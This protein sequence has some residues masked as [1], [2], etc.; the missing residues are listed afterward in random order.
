[1]CIFSGSVEEVKNTKILV[2]KVYPS[3]LVNRLG[4]DGHHHK[5]KIPIASA[6]LQLVIYSNEVAIGE[7]YAAMVLPFP[8]RKGDNRIK[9]L[10][11]SGYVNIFDDLDSIFP[12]AA[13]ISQ[14]LR[15]ADYNSSD[16]LPVVQV[17]SYRATLVPNWRSFDKVQHDKF[18]LHPNTRD[19]LGKHYRNNYGFIVCQLNS[20][21]QEYHP[22]A[23]CHE[24]RH[25]GKLFIPTRHYHPHSEGMEQKYAQ[26]NSEDPE[27]RWLRHNARRSSRDVTVDW[28]HDIY[29]INNPTLQRNPLFVRKH[30]INVQLVRFEH[31]IFSYVDPTKLPSSFAFGRVE[32]LAKISIQ[33]GYPYNHDFVV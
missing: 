1:M 12:K 21:A 31:G 20:S 6:P 33:P 26:L 29:V 25:D 30:S 8:L 15:S 2:S 5:I 23:Y 19:L 11:L 7:Q 32:Y 28:D 17:G 13:V 22:F 27:E 18:S 4:D 14:D 9:M 10:D 3:R 24:L 16:S